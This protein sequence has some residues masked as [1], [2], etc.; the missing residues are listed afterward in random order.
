MAYVLVLWFGY[1]Q[2][3]SSFS[4]SGIASQ[5]ECQRLGEQ[6]APHYNHAEFRCYA[7]RLAKP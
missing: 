2:Q 7:Y 5:A 3:Q 4:V 1:L 6:M